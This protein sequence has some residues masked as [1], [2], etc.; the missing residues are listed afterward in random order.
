MSNPLN[1]SGSGYAHGSDLCPL[2]GQE[3]AQIIGP[4]Y[5][6]QNTRP[7]GKVEEAEG[8]EPTDKPNGSGKGVL[9]H[10]NKAHLATYN[11]F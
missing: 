11:N 4:N 1:R 3:L 5:Q 10:F 9:L 6:R 8:K 2:T 7:E